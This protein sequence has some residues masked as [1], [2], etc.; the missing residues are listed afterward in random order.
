MHRTEE[1]ISLDDKELAC[2]SCFLPCSLYLSMLFKFSLL[3]RR[4]PF[5]SWRPTDRLLVC[6]LNSCERVS[7][8]RNQ[9]F[10]CLI[11]MNVQKTRVYFVQ[12]R[13]VRAYSATCAKG[14]DLKGDQTVESIVL[15]QVIGQQ[16]ST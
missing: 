16:T 2:A 8:K 9:Y 4:S 12:V 13:S 6:L 10:S 1:Q 11:V 15:I 7:V 14:K 5:I 3:Q